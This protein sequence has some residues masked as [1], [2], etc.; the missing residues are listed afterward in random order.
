[1]KV[2]I[3][4][5]TPQEIA[6]IFPYLNMR[7]AAATTPP[8]AVAAP[9]RSGTTEDD[10]PQ[11]VT[12]EVARRVLSRRPLSK[13]QLLLLRE[14][15]NAYPSTVSGI[16]LQAKLGYIRPQFTGLMGAMGRRF[17]H[18]EGFVKGTWFFQQEWDH[19]ATTNRY[20]L[21]ETVREAMR[22][23]KLV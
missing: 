20:G 1:M 15:Y 14:L 2:T 13:E 12:V 4:E 6:E 21:P 19:K 3:V 7:Q 17:T 8:V 16:D 18:T 9:Q 22:L 23:E 10:E 5:G 11:Y